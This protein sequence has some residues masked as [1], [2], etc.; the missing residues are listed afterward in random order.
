MSPNPWT[1]KSH[2]LFRLFFTIVRGLVQHTPPNEHEQQHPLWQQRV[3]QFPT[4]VTQH[5]YPFG[6]WWDRLLLLKQ[7]SF[8]DYEFLVESVQ[9]NTKS[10]NVRYSVN[11]KKGANFE[12]ATIDSK[13]GHYQAKETVVEYAVKWLLDNGFNKR[14]HWC[15]VAP[16]PIKCGPVDVSKQKPCYEKFP[17]LFQALCAH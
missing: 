7:Y 1:L 14:T 11:E 10:A 3:S 8:F 4:Q 2:R 6:F 12:L 5:P 13:T 16:E 15:S 9:R 17:H